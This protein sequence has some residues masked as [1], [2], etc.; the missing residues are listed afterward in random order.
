MAEGWVDFAAEVSVVVARGDDGKAACYPVALN[1][2]ERHILDTSLM[3]API[4]PIVTHEARGLAMAIAQALG[5][6][7]VLTVEFF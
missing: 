2:H 5:T 1:R 6:V 3:P 7:G 4:G